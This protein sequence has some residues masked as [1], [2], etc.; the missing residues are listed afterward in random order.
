MSKYGSGD[1]IKNSESVY[2][3]HYLIENT[4]KDIS[5][6]PLYVCLEIET[7]IRFTLRVE[8]LDACG[9]IIQVA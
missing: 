1:I 7:N 4:S 8:D 6:V 2:D 9:T 5:G 3:N